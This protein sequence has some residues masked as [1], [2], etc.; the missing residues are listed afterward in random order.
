V[1]GF[2]R[3][4]PSGRVDRRHLRGL[5]ERVGVLQID[6]VNVLARSH[7][8]P[9]WSRLGA[10]PRAALDDYVHRD[11]HAYEYWAHEASLIPVEWQPLLRWRAERALAG[12]GIWRGLA[13]FGRERAPYLASVLAEIAQRGPIS[14][15]EL[16]APGRAGGTWWGWGDGKRALEFL[17]W[18]GQVYAAGRRATFERCY[19]LPE[20]VIPAPVLAVATPEPADAHRALLTHAADRLGVATAGDLADYFRLPAALVRPRLIELVEAGE[21]ATVRVEGWRAPAY[22]RPR[23]VIPR[24]VAARALLSPFD[25]LIWER[26]RTRRLFGMDVKLE[27]YTP[28]EQRRYGYYVLPFLLGDRL[29]ARVDLKSDRA[30]GVLRVLAAWD[31]RAADAAP[32][33]SSTSTRAP[34]SLQVASTG[35]PAAPVTPVTT[36]APV[37]SVSSV[38]SVSPV[39]PV[40]PRPRNRSGGVRGLPSTDEIAT[41]LAAELIAFAAWLGLSDVDVASRGTLAAALRRAVRAG[42]VVETAAEQPAPE[43]ARVRGPGPD[44]TE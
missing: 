16:S 37:S 26:S 1:Q 42:P 21:L 8:L 44:P 41:A 13:E 24:R 14:A 40:P 35:R 20:R 25:S 9:G 36:I 31:E 38:S 3:P 6:S 34:L 11:R 43:P 15:A 32:S 30:A 18:T 29:V 4:R 39:P 2:A 33:P 19:D 27:V 10:Y 12:E 22:L 17:L 5:F 7:Y 23:L 28:A